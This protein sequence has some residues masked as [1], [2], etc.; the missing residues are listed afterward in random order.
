MTVKASRKPQSRRRYA[1]EPQPGARYDLDYPRVTAH[2]NELLDCREDKLFY[3]YLR[4]FS[5]A[6][7]FFFAYFVLGLRGLNH[8]WL[9]ARVR[10]VQDDH[11]ETLDLWFREA[12]KSTIISYALPIWEIREDPETSIAIFSH[13]RALAKGFLRRIKTTLETNKLLSAAWPEIFY[14][15]PAAESPKWSED[16]GLI[17]R[18]KG[19][20]AE[21][22]LEAWGVVEAMPTG[23]HFRIRDYDDVVTPE[24]VTTLA[25]I[26]KTRERFDLSDALGQKEGTVR[27]VGTRYDY[28]DLYGTMI[29]QGCWKPRVYPCR[30]ADGRPILH[31]E[32]QLAK[33]R[34]RM[35]AYI[36]SCQMELCPIAKENQLFQRGWFEVREAAPTTLV[37]VVR[38]WDR[39]ATDAKDASPSGPWTAGI[40]MAKDHQGCY[41]ILDVDRFQGSPLTVEARIKNTASQD[42]E[43]VRVG[44]EQDPGQA[45]KAEA[46]LQ[47]RNLAGYD[48]RVNAVREAKGVRARSF[49]AQAEAGNVKLIRGPWIED[50]LRELD[51]FDGSR[52]CMADQ[53]DASSGA[54]LLLTQGGRAGAFKW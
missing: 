53:V 37:D 43:L 28:D 27:V 41:W 25:Q 42:G 29:D 1:F 22:T 10:E 31:T 9:V 6:S 5:E 24:S 3:A 38:Y 20:Y 49:S 45:G 19:V 15:N 46:Q 39:A 48:A 17:V 33:K 7:L 12:W 52:G 32:A 26:Q 51:R 16:D 35:G 40:L 4:K 47:V 30:H 11:N 21:A 14:A 54:F 34:V 50:Y 18:R 13:T 23:K 2:L 8:P 44:I 36:Y